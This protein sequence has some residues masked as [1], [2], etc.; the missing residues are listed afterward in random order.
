MIEDIKWFDESNSFRSRYEGNIPYGDIVIQK[1]KYN[2]GVTVYIHKNAQLSF[3]G[4]YFIHIAHIDKFTE[5]LKVILNERHKRK[6]LIRKVL[7]PGHDFNYNCHEIADK[8]LLG[9][10][11]TTI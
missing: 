11:G 9:D 1:D 4:L 8:I 3:D 10:F 2:H 5:E 6:G 7:Y